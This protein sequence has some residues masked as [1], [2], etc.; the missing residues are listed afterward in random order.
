MERLSSI[1]F[2]LINLHRNNHIT[3]NQSGFRPG[4]FTPNQL[5]Y[6]FDEINQAFDST[7]CFVVRTVYLDIP[8]DFDKV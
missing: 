3:K 8:K 1:I 6:L 5:L 2:T 7:E 4:D